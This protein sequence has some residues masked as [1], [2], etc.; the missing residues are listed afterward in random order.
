MRRSTVGDVTALLQ[1]WGHGDRAALNLLMPVVYGE[2]RRVAASY[3]RRERHNHILQPTGLVHEAYLRLM[4]QRQAHWQNR[5]QFFGVA[6]SLMRRILVDHA[7][8]QRAAKRGG[9]QVEQLDSSVAIT[10][11]R[12][13]PV[14]ALHDALTRLAALD[15]IQARVVE[16]RCFGGM[17]IVEVA[18]SLGMSTDAVKR[19]WRL[20]KAWL[21]REL[22]N[23]TNG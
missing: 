6:A 4:D 19:E 14:L 13:A 5:A 16:L 18:A 8:R 3:L 21:Y 11:R 7:R 1:E 15:G 22:K 9:G 2:L 10:S 17:T 20:A 23:G 12:D